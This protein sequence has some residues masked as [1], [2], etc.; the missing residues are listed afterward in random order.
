[1][2]RQSDN[3]VSQLNTPYVHKFSADQ[4]R[5]RVHIRRCRRI[6]LAFLV[7]F[8]ILGVQIF[9]S[10]RTLA[11]V[12]GNINQCQ[13]QLK[14]ERQNS[15]QLKQRIRLLHDPDYVQQV[16]RAKYNYSKKGETVYNLDN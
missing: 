12:N 14:E 5:R 3:N 8:I 16:V 9:Q 4:H 1:M 6:L 7:I 15:R 10:K 11:R 2:K 13:A